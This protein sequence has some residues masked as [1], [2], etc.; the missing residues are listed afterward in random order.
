M[1]LSRS[2]LVGFVAATTVST[3]ED[4]CRTGLAGTWSFTPVRSFFT[5]NLTIQQ[6]GCHLNVSWW[7]H[8]VDWPCRGQFT[9]GW[10][11]VMSKYLVQDE[12]LIPAGSDDCAGSEGW[13]PD[14]MVLVNGGAEALGSSEVWRKEPPAPP[15][16]PLPSCLSLD[17]CAIGFHTGFGPACCEGTFLQQDYS[18]HCDHAVGT[19]GYPEAGLSCQAKQCLHMG[20]DCHE[21]QDACCPG[22]SCMDMGISGYMCAGGSR[23]VVYQ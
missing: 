14:E 8:V 20:S 21:H 12:R 23:I 7:E 17:E 6:H 19:R 11:E 2:L 15:K 18:S 5:G 4:T 3:L 9:T 16:P 10:I 13:R 1:N 22:L